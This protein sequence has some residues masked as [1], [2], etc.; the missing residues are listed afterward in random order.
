MSQMS[1]CRKYTFRGLVF[2]PSHSSD[3]HLFVCVLTSCICSVSSHC[4]WTTLP[5]ILEDKCTK[6][7]FSKLNT[8]PH[9][10]PVNAVSCLQPLASPSLAQ[11]TAQSLCV[12][13]HQFQCD[14]FYIKL[15]LCVGMQ[16]ECTAT[17]AIK[18]VVTADRL[19]PVYT[20]SKKIEKKKNR[21]KPEAAA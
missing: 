14:A 19:K 2:T 21:E 1:E 18:I 13:L 10:I 4:I 17:Y 12:S 11:F 15:A 16:R 8:P 6:F 5:Q 9:S 7:T 20:G 3:L